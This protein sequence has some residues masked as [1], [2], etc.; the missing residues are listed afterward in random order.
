MGMLNR[1]ALLKKQKLEIEKVEFENGDFVFVRQMTGRERDRY[2]QTLLKKVRG[3][4]KEIIYENTLDDFRAKLAV[5][6]LCDQEGNLLLTMKDMETLSENMS[7]YNLEKIV[8]VAQRLNA[9]TQEDQEDA[10]K[11]LEVGQADNSTSDSAEN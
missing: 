1:D 9:I 10:V 7:A 3:P 2:E 4:K 5:S 8:D 6:T 11:N